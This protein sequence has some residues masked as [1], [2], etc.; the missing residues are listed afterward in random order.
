MTSTASLEYT[1]EAFVYVAVSATHAVTCSP[2]SVYSANQ[3]A[4]ALPLRVTSVLCAISSTCSAPSGAGCTTFS[5]HC[6]VKVTS[7]AGMVYM[8]PASY[9]DVPSL[10]CVKV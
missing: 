10:H 5:S 8:A 6:A 1:F 7:W 4:A 9:S 3:F 2:A